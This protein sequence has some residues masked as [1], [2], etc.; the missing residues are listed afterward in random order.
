ML[1]K[2]WQVDLKGEVVFNLAYGLHHFQIQ[3]HLQIK[4]AISN[5][6]LQLQFAISIYICAHIYTIHEFETENANLTNLQNLR[7]VD[8]DQFNLSLLK[9]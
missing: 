7:Y 4:I 5:F 8:S 1:G 3:F 2:F 9:R 6:K